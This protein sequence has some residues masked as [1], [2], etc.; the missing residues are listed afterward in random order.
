MTIQIMSNFQ[1]ISRGKAQA[2][3]SISKHS[4]MQM[5]GLE[6]ASAVLPLAVVVT[7]EAVTS[8]TMALS[9]MEKVIL[10]TTLVV[11]AKVILVT[12][13]AV[14][15][16]LIMVTTQAVTEKV[17][18]AT[19]QA[20]MGI[21]ALAIILLIVD[22]VTLATTLDLVE[23]VVLGITPSIPTA[24]ARDTDLVNAYSISGARRN[25]EVI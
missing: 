1:Q 13:L 10:V 15:E 2:S 18:L 16:N 11:M 20:I 14:T 4:E 23:K 21:I 9:V 3:H 22:K 19:D 7:L 25:L 6:E 24:T 17:T 8:S 12:T 5:P